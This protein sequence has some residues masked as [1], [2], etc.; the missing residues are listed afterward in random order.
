MK[1]VTKDPVHGKLGKV[2][3]PDQQVCIVLC[4]WNNKKGQDCVWHDKLI[5]GFYWIQVGK[6]ALS[7]DI[8]GLKR[9][10]REAK[11]NKEHSKKQKINPE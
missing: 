2:Y 4:F 10:R 3:M 7:S 1:N 5:H 8:K 9:E 6:L 11:K